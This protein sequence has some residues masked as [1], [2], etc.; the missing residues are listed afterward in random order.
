VKARGLCPSFIRTDK[1]TE[2]ILLAD[3]HFSF[4]IEAALRE[5]WSDEEYD[6]IRI[7]DCYIYG[8]ST[9]NVRIEGL[10]RQQ[11][12]TTTGPWIS[13]FKLLSLSGFYEQQSLADKMV[14]LY[15][16]MPIIRS[17][18]TRNEHHRKLRVLIRDNSGWLV[19]ADVSDFCRPPAVP[20]RC[21][22]PG[23]YSTFRTSTITCCLPHYLLPPT[24]TCYLPRLSAAST[25]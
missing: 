1:G 19:N 9:G 7:T 10:W 4:C 8:P 12:Y 20:G 15:I 6:A 22:R 16:F 21:T 14:L 13:Y 23:R 2:T 11:R 24:T 3:A 5:G 25:Q 17:R 18:L